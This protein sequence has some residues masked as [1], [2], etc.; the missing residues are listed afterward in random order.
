M[1][2]V[3]LSPQEIDLNVLSF[4]EYL[5]CIGAT[6]TNKEAAAIILLNFSEFW[7]RQSSDANN[8]EDLR[9]FF[10]Y[11]SFCKIA[12]ENLCSS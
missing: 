1:S 12:S 7:L 6:K 3:I 2:V 11:H 10:L 8:Q 9:R 4:K 5:N